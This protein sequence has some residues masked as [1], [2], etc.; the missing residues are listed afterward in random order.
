MK[1]NDVCGSLM[2]RLS[3]ENH[4][5]RKAKWET[6]RN[7]RSRKTDRKGTTKCSCGKAWEC[8]KVRCGIRTDFDSFLR[9]VDGGAVLEDEVGKS[10][11]AYTVLVKAEHRQP[12]A[13]ASTAS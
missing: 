13:Y 12:A 6:A 9:A 8:C 3:D 4:F 5:A 11:L 10:A 1:G 7:N 2:R